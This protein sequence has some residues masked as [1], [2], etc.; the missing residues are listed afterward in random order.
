MVRLGILKSNCKIYYRNSKR[1]HKGQLVMNMMVHFN[2]IGLLTTSGVEQKTPYN[3][4]T[5]QDCFPTR[6][7][8]IECHF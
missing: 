6:Q 4:N 8:I 3:Q 1:K 5:S 2:K 7:K